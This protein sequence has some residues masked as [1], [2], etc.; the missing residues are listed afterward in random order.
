MS[1]C[2]PKAPARKALGLP[3]EAR[4]AGIGTSVRT[5]GCYRGVIDRHDYIV[6]AYVFYRGDLS[7]R[8]DQLVQQALVEALRQRGGRPVLFR[9]NMA[10]R[11]LVDRGEP[12]PVVS[13]RV[14]WSSARPVSAASRQ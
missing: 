11:V 9:Q 4:E 10:W 3:V 7:L 12:D 1:I 5:N 2:Q 6:S 13:Q 8:E 14:A